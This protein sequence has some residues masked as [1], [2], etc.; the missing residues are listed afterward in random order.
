MNGIGLRRISLLLA[1]VSFGTLTALVLV[2]QAAYAIVV[3]QWEYQELD[4]PCSVEG[5]GLFVE[6]LAG[7][8]GPLFE[9]GTGVEVLNAAA[10]VL[11]NPQEDWVVYT[12]ICVET[13]NDRF[14][15]EG[16]LLPPYSRT[17][18]V[19]KTGKKL[20]KSAITSCMGWSIR[21]KQQGIEGVDVLTDAQG[22]VLLHNYSE[23][24][25]KNLRLFHKNYL[26][27]CNLFVG[28]KPFET[29]IHV[30]NPGQSLHLMPEN[31][32]RGYSRILCVIP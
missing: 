32:A 20:P 2:S 27:D 22:G 23:A 11:H 4:M 6:N 1:A 3:R 31:F 19:E 24:T 18:I 10:I 17:L 21:S 14:V 8:D 28:G 30:I 9:D 16:Q 15:F 5:T 25:M 12:K 26:E 13:E 7:Y 29:N